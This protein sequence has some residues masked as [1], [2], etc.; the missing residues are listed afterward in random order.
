MRVMVSLFVTLDTDEHADRLAEVAGS[1]ARQVTGFG[2]D[3]FDCGMSVGPEEVEGS[4]EVL[5]FTP[6]DEGAGS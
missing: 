6:D 1:F 3:G 5:T 4:D 2:M